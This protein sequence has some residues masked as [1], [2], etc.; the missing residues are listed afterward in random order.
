MRGPVGEKEV[1]LLPRIGLNAERLG[2]HRA[3]SAAK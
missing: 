2:D 1:G 3:R